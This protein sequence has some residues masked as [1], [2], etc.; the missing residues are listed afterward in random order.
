MARVWTC[1]RITAGQRCGHQNP[2]RKRKCE[3]CGL[4]RP[5]LSRPAHM[6][7]LD[8]PYEHYV[9]I[10]GGEFCGICGAEPKDG[11]RLNRDHLHE[12]EGTPRG[13]LCWYCNKAL[14]NRIGSRWLRAA[15]DYVE[16]A[17][18]GRIPLPERVEA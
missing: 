2:G 14:P 10:N 8:L 1:R 11:R 13:L 5:A 12:N 9:E 6:A 4:P 15:A 7:A 3:A 18:E 17:E 16:R